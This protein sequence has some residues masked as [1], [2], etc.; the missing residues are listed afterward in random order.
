[1]PLPRPPLRK[2][3]R[4][5]SESKQLRRLRE[6]EQLLQ[7]KSP[8]RRNKPE[9]AVVASASAN[10]EPRRRLKQSLAIFQLNNYARLV[11]RTTPYSE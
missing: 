11:S 4:K 2:R 10:A 9:N 8:Q 6:K 5:F 7:L 1:M 3:E